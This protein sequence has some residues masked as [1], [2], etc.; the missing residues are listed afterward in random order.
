[1]PLE[2]NF[3]YVPWKGIGF[4]PGEEGRMIGLLKDVR[5][6]L[7]ALNT[8]FSNKK[9]KE[10]LNAVEEGE[11]KI[12]SNKINEESPKAE[13]IYTVDLSKAKQRVNQYRHDSEGGCKSC[14]KFGH[15]MPLQDEHVLYCKA[16]EK[17]DVV[18]SGESPRISKF[19]KNGCDEKDIIIQR[20]LEE[21]LK[22]AE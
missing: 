14:K 15:Y 20:K 21:I 9:L 8:E 17:C 7:V 11:L 4:I 18:D 19:Y 1:M 3:V 13:I 16:H 5:E 12:K 10:I 2:Q 22:Y 6:N